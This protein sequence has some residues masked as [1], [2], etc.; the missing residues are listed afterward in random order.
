MQVL[1]QEPVNI[2]AKLKEHEYRNVWRLVISLI[3][4][5]DMSKHF[6]ILDEIN[7]LF[8]K[9]QWSMEEP[10][11]RLILLEMLLKCGDLSMVARP[12]EIADKWKDYVYEEFF[13]YGNLERAVGLVYDGKQERDNLNKGK[14]FVGFCSSVAL[15]LFDSMLLA[16]PKLE[17]NALQ[18]RANLAKWKAPSESQPPASSRMPT[19]RAHLA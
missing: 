2:F 12:F 8:T 18:V 14:S 11:C 7:M 6:D 10:R 3:L 4:A 17:P 15:P 5:T 13:R 1:S 16:V 9:R 19:V